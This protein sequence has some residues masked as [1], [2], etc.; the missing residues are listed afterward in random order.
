MRPLW[1]ACLLLHG[2][3]L[4]E[5]AA[6][7]G[8]T[9]PLVD[10]ARPVTRLERTSATLQ[11]HTRVPS[12]TRL[13]V[14]LGDMPMHTPRPGRPRNPW[15]GADVRVVNGPAGL[16]SHHVLRVGGLRPA[17]R[18]TYR[19][20]DPGAEPTPTEARWGAAKPWR[21][22]FSFSTLAPAGR[23]TVIRIPVKVLLMPNVLNVASAHG[24]S[25]AL[26]PPPPLMSDADLRRI[27]AEYADSARF[28]FG[29]NGF[30]V[31]YDFRIYVDARRQRWGEEPAN[32]DRAYAGWPVCR[33]WAGSDY[34][35]PGGGRFTIVD[36]RDIERVAE[37][38]VHEPELYVG[39]IE[40]AFVR[41]W[42]PQRR[43]WEFYGSGGGA[44]GIDD[45][46]RGV[47]SRSQY[48]G[49]GDT[50]WL[51]THEFHHQIES[52]GT[53]SLANRED[54]RVVFNHYFP[55]RR[56][57]RADGR[58]EEWTWST[59]F[60][61]GEHY[62]GMAYTDRMLT[63]LQW[64]RLHFGQTIS[65]RD[66]DGDGVPDN[67]PRL[68]LD[69]RRIGSSPRSARTDGAMHDYDKATLSHW[70]PYAPLT[71]SWLKAPHPRIRPNPRSRDSDGDGLAD[72]DDPVPLNPYPPFVWPGRAVI[73]GDATEWRDV[74][75]A[76]RIEAHGARVTFQQ[77]YDAE[78]YYGCLVARG[79]WERLHVAL[80]GE[81]QGFFS[82]DAVYTFTVTAGAAGAAPELRPTSGNRCPGLT[83]RAS[84]AP[85]GS[86]VVEFRI[87]NRGES[88]WF[89]TGAGREI[90]W[91]INGTVD[92]GKPIDLYEP[93]RF[94][95]CRMLEPAGKPDPLTGGPGP[96][97]AADA[98][99]DFDFAT[100]P[101]GPEWRFV[102]GNWA[103]Q[104]GAVRF[105]QGHDGEN[106]L[107][108]DGFGAREFD[109]WVEFEAGSD[110]HIGAWTADAQRT[111]NMTDYVAFVGGFGNARSVIRTF[112]DE[113]AGVEAGVEPGRRTM[114]F[115]RRGRELWLLYDG[116]P[117][118]RADDPAP[119]R[120]VN[121]LGFLGGWG[122]RQ[123]IHRVRIRAQ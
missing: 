84:V 77:R 109:I 86:A 73:D 88:L 122:G 61:H 41:R 99:R 64:L 8:D 45:W 113:A 87:P 14:R 9:R 66:A 121:R 96:L 102:Q 75:L 47:P 53:F 11:W 65:V 44:L 116:K 95:Y 85:D 24:A 100:Q 27:K 103:Q 4:A 70:A 106:Y 21:R 28:F 34:E 49:G 26:T 94:V 78:A 22:E 91:Y 20:Y 90:G 46:D 37:P 83:W 58:W 92:G 13:Q 71:S 54:D 72:G 57:K 67:D 105:V 12:P 60:R 10:P 62:D 115:T 111:D 19:I 18:Y 16:R 76:G 108:L 101:M 2:P 120:A 118:V 17:T 40:Q 6:A 63:P 112:G 31:W 43:E 52:L 114:Q 5:R 82:T 42:V 3:G 15:V 89:W 55:R 30:R 7:H 117:L 29:N 48:L 36:T 32:V 1:L 69:E 119:D 80:D 35:G 74:P 23:M 59:S 107:L 104:D 51:A 25:G 50:A 98:Q 79:P 38:P 68:P 81:G 33:S 123:V 39:Q 56:V 93:F 110:M 97:S